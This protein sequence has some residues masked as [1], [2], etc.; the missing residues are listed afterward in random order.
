MNFWA[1]ENL[2]AV[3]GG[4]WL[5]RPADETIRGAG[6]DSRTIRPGQVFVALP[7][8]H[9]DGA[10]FLATARAAGSPLAIVGPGEI[11]MPEGMGVLQVGCARTALVR[12]ATALR[13]QF[14][15]LKVVAVTGSC[16]KTTT[17][18]LIDAVLRQRLRGSASVKSF[19]NDIGVPLTL[20][21]VG[22][23]DQY[24][25]CEVGTSGP[26]EIERLARMCDP[27]IAVI[28]SIGRAHL[29]GLSSIEGVA[30][31]KA[32]LV[33]QMRATGFGIVPAEAVAL[34]PFLRQVPAER[35]IRFGMVDDA[36]V[37]VAGVETGLGGT[38]FSINGRERYRIGLLGAHNALNA[39]CAVMVGR[40]LGLG[41]QEIAAGLLEAK[42]PDMRLETRRV[43]PITIINDAYNANPD[44]MLA[45][46]R[47]L[48][49]LGGA[50][51][52][53]VLG[54]MLELG[55]TSEREHEA[56]GAWIDREHPAD[57]VIGVGAAAGRI[58]AGLT[59][60]FPEADEAAIEGI[61]GLIEPGDTVL[62]KGSRGVALERVARALEARF[63]RPAAMEAGL[64]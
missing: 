33:V 48:G 16:G 32:Q 11:E 40:R 13:T 57:V 30:C 44:S 60:R 5:A 2:R 8:E 10:R 34:E 47:T 53:A 19:N 56:L 20:L 25:V 9:T 46:L 51:R 26:G 31:E 43:G 35:L 58:S 59:E 3:T 1:P 52:V 36:D 12:M 15:S 42:G 22:A 6:I 14:A 41:V 24:V 55:P 54:D 21:N 29:Q 23:G 38:S 62:I 63:G 28:T 45:A 64:S 49:G 50:R 27:D 61:V 18:R 17:V 37:R 4:V 39:A 7:G